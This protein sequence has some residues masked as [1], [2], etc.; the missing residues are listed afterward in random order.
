VGKVEI[1]DEWFPELS[2]N[3]KG[4]IGEGI[5]KTHLRSLLDTRPQVLFPVFQS[6]D[7]SSMY[8]QVRHYRRFTYEDI[9]TD[10]E[11]DRIQW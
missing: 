9:K 8:T 6:V 1:T 4:D 7:P 11:I 5:V 2:S 3:R 10:G